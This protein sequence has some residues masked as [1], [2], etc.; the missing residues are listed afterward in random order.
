[1]SEPIPASDSSAPSVDA[2]RR[3]LE[4]AGPANAGSPEALTDSLVGPADGDLLRRCAVPHEFDAALLAWIGDLS[5]G[6]AELRFEK[7]NDLSIVQAAGDASLG[8]HERWRAPTPMPTSRA[9]STASGR[10][11]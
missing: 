10:C 4:S 1:M 6:E 9:C 8:I 2:L 7:F 5:A 11:S 3:L